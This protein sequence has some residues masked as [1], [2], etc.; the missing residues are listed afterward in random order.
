MNLPYFAGW[1]ASYRRFWL[2]SFERLD[3]YLGRLQDRRM[4]TTEKG[5]EPCE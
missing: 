4:K 1:F 3:E 5:E 2:A